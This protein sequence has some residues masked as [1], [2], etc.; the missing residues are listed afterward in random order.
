[1][2]GSLIQG[3][4]GLE[5]ADGIFLAMTELVMENVMG[6]YIKYAGLNCL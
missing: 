1:M 2:L 4:R 6:L 5:K 3:S